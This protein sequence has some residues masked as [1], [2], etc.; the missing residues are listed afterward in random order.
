MKIGILGGTFDPVHNGHIKIANLA[1]KELNLDKVLFIPNSVPPH[2]DKCGISNDDKLNMLKL[3]TEENDKFEIETFE[4]EREGVSYLYLTLEYLKEKYKDDELY[5]IC[6]SD[7]ITTISGW[8]KPHLIF[9]YANIVFVKRPEH[10]LDE[11]IIKKLVDLYKGK[12]RIIDFK[13]IK[14]SSTGIRE[15]LENFSL[16]SGLIP[17]KV[18]DYIY[19]NALYPQNVKNKLKE[20]LNDKRYIHSLNV[21]KCAYKLSKHYKED[22]EK[23]YYAGLIHDCAKNIDE[24]KQL[25]LIAEFNTYDLMDNELSFPK[26]IHALCGPIVAR[27]LFGVEDKKI[28]DAIRYHTLGNI[29]MTLFDKIIYIA[30]L[31]SDERNYKGV[32]ILREMSYNNID[33]AII[34]SIDNTLSYLNGKRVQPDVIK[35]RDFLRS[36]QNGNT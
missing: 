5:F 21:A 36:K 27:S 32:E 15:S 14:I 19:L 8:K 10:R 18:K 35:L 24:D 30:D 34:T 2:K 23:A 28:L 12:I 9:K 11:K 25:E 29:K 20:I 26:V 17:D 1:L 22:A 4:L 3:A 7:N 16:V 31:I 33:M 6:G 13:G